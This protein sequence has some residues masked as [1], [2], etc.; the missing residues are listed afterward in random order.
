MTRVGTRSPSSGSQGWG[1]RTEPA[2][3]QSRAGQGAG[4]VLGRGGAGEAGRER[5]WGRP[6]QVPVRSARAVAAGR[7]DAISP[8][9][10]E[11]S[12][13]PVALRCPGLIFQGFFFFSGYSC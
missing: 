6:A 10:P 11:S 7:G 5:R 12:A 4:A 3:G 13:W 9:L 8:L 1:S 2:G